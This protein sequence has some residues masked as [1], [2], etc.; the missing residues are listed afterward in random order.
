MTKLLGFGLLALL[1]IM[2]VMATP[3]TVNIGTPGGMYN[4]SEYGHFITFTTGSGLS[5]QS[6]TM[7]VGNGAYFDTTGSSPLAFSVTNSSGPGVGFLTPASVADNATTFTM[8]FTNGAF[9]QGETF[10]Y[11]IDIDN[12]NG[13]DDICDAT[14][15][16]DGNDV[17]FSI[18]V[19]GAGYQTTTVSGWYNFNESLN[20]NN[21]GG[22]SSYARVTLT[23]D[24]PATGGG[25]VPEP[26]TTA[27][28]GAGLG[29]L[30]LLARRRKG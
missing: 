18:V 3:I 29:L 12:C 9:T 23:G 16:D 17:Y 1:V 26:V 4:D 22:S 10:S 14:E 21:S 28:V 25:A 20:R 5:I 7:T 8:T 6:A 15:M 19:A 13:G 27:L 2:P 24:A 30:G 11:N